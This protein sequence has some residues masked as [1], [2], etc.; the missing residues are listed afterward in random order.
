[1]LQSTSYSGTRERQREGHKR[2]W[3]KLTRRPPTGN[4]FRPP[5]LGTFCPLRDS[6]NFPQLTSSETAFGGSQKVVS[7]APSSRGFAF[8][9]VLPPPPP[10]FSSAQWD[11]ECRGQTYSGSGNM[12]HFVTDRP[13]LELTIVSSNFRFALLAGQM[14]GISRTVVNSSKRV[15][16]IIGPSLSRANSVII[17]A[18]TVVVDS[19]LNSGR[20]HN[21]LMCRQSTRWNF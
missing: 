20:S 11:N 2:G 9:Y 6:Q 18:R 7:D 12:F 1:M 15:F 16:Q 19:S 14:T 21:Q 4:G 17:S 8:R 3:A 10:R 13:C 5:H